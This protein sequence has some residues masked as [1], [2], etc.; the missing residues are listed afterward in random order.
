MIVR[1][2]GVVK[3]ATTSGQLVQLS[4]FMATFADLLGAKLPT[5]AGEDSISF[6]PVLRGVDQPVHDFIISASSPGVLTVRRGPW[7]FI[8]GN[9]A[10]D[11]GGKKSNGELYNL[12]DDLGETKNLY[13]RNPRIVAD[14]TALLEKAV[15]DGRTTP[16]PRESNDVPVAWRRFLLSS[17]APFGP[18]KPA[19]GLTAAQEKWTPRQKFSFFHDWGWMHDD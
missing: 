1:W 15:D 18:G 13:N 7:K 12:S 11:A 6:L 5:T 8:A 10:A 19:D 17:S 14:L 16:G 4:D 2:P 3:P 9:G